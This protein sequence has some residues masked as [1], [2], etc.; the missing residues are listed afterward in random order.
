MDATGRLEAELVQVCVVSLED[1]ASRLTEE[2][3]L[4]FVPEGRE[5]FDDD[6]AAVDEIAYAGIIDLGEVAAEQLALALDPYPRKPGETLP[7]LDAEA[8]EMPEKPHPFAAL[9][10]LKTPRRDN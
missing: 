1:F 8:D 2:F 6:P 9:A 10:A 7:E 3:S 5:N 4:R